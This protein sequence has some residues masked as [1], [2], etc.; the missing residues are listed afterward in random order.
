[1][2]LHPLL[3]VLE[4][5]DRW[6][7]LLLAL[8]FGAV[9][10][11]AASPARQQQIVSRQLLAS[12][13]DAG[14]RSIVDVDP[15]DFVVHESGQPRDVLSIRIADYPIAVVL[16]NSR[17]AARDFEAIRRATGHFV[18]RIGHRPIAI[19]VANPP[20]M[21]AT[22]DDDR[23]TVIER[24]NKLRKGD[25]ADGLFNAVVTAARTIQETGAP[26]SAVIVV[27]AKA[28]G[29]VPADLLTP[30]LDSGTNVY[31]VVQ[32][33]IFGDAD[34]TARQSRDTLVALVD[35]THGALTTIDSPASYQTALDRLANQLATEWIIE[36]V[37]AAGSS[38]GSEVQLGVR[39]PGAKAYNWGVSRRR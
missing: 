33:K 38:S 7:Q 39:V 37:V 32:Q 11:G 23:A 6:L 15:D 26:F 36:Y 29:P 10:Y 4:K 28:G 22:F 3:R 8:T 9:L 20:R 35:E 21:I 31:V 19:A 14:G 27:V 30:I 5:R 13:T 24:V 25:S 18:D 16:D 1:M 17:G 2:S 12:V 34:T